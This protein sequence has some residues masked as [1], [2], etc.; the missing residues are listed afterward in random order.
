MKNSKLSKNFAMCSSK[1]VKKMAV[2]A[3]NS[4]SMM[5]FHQPIEPKEMKKF[6]K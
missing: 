2:F 4:A 3:A 6:K 5:G 1:L